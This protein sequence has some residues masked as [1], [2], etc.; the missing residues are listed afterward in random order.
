MPPS[1]IQ[2]YSKELAQAKK[3]AKKAASFLL[4]N[5]N[6]HPSL[7]KNRSLAKNITTKYDKQS[8]NIILSTLK[9][10]FPSHSFLTEEHGLIKKPNSSSEFF[11]IIDPLDGTKNFAMGNPFFSVSIALMHN[12]S[13]VLGVVCAPALKEFYFAVKGKGAFLNNR[14]IKVSSVKEIKNSYILSCSGGESSTKKYSSLLS[15]FTPV[16]KDTR[17]L[18]SAALECCYVASGRA[19]AYITLKISPWDVA[20]GILIAEEAGALSSDFNGLPWKRKK[21]NLLVSNPFLH[22]KILGKLRKQQTL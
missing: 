15:L 21:T 12:S 19:D 2:Q 8:D 14:K 1:P 13:L 4:K 17:K 9:K 18:G 16:S 3:A 6:L 7:Y 20:A 11:W 22:R 10:S 5:F